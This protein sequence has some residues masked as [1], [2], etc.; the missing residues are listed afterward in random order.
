MRFFYI[1]ALILYVIAG[2]AAALPDNQDETGHVAVIPEPPASV[3]YEPAAAVS[4]DSYLDKQ[5]AIPKIKA[6]QAWQV[7]SGDA[8]VVIA[9]L[10]TGINCNHEDLDG[11]VMA[12]VNF[13]DS[14]TCDDIYGHGTHVAGIIAATANNG[15]GIAGLAYDCH[16][17][18]VK[19]ADDRGRF[20]SSALAE[21]IIWAADHGAHVINMSLFTTTPSPSLEKAVDYAWEQGAIV[22]SAAGNY[23]GKRL[24]YPAYYS[25]CIAVAATDDTDSVTL[26]SSHGDWVDVAA[27]GVSIY[28]TL[29]GNEYG[30]KSGTSMATPYV[31]GV[32][33]LL[34]TVAGDNNENGLINDEVRAAIESNCDDI[35][36]NS[37]SNGRINAFEAVTGPLALEESSQSS[38]MLSPVDG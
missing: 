2:V 18:N 26:W 38:S 28:S 16:L 32:A 21:G 12:R 9:V 17:M 20:D 8:D 13:T 25:N 33:G 36:A 6:P 14:P 31:S 22:V 30:S 11:K 4:D 19:V 37:T 5:W 24:A 29:P 3:R 27:P 10:D 35:E 1:L 23:I 34:F 15:I 7:T